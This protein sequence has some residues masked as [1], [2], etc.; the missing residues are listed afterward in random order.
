MMMSHLF[1]ESLTVCHSPKVMG[2]SA[3]MTA[4]P[5]PRLNLNSGTPWSRPK[6]T[7]SEPPLDVWP[8]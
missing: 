7:K 1:L 6:E 3:L 5:E 2:L 8:L 4:A